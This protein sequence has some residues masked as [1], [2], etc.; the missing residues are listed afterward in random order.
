MNLTRHTDYGLRVLMVLAAA[1]QRAEPKVSTSEIAGLFDISLH[2]L[3]KIVQDL[4]QAGYVNTTRGRG[5]GLTLAMEPSA[6]GIGDVVRTLEPNQNV[7][8]CFGN[9]ACALVPG[10]G[11]KGV[12]AG[13]Q[14]AFYAQL[15]AVSLADITQRSP[16]LKTLV[17][18]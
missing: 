11:L 5:G 15:D 6:V 9:N 16:A 2:H 1:R 10:C 12:L 18:D 3:H 14:R 7:V 8:E 17:P 13:A 4:N